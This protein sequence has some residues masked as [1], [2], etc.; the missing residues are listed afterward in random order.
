VRGNLED[1]HP[2]NGA[3][4]ALPNRSPSQ[5]VPIVHPTRTSRSGE[6]LPTGTRL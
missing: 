1:I 2:A 5:L 4:E 6:S 3:Q